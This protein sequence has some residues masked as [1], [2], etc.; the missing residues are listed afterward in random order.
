MVAEKSLPI[1]N[2]PGSGGPVHK[3]LLRAFNGYFQ[4]QK[5]LG[6]RQIPHADAV[7]DPFGAVIENA[8]LLTFPVPPG[9]QYVSVIGIIALADKLFKLVEIGPLLRAEEFPQDRFRA[10]EIVTFDTELS[11]G[12]ARLYH[13][14][15][16]HARRRANA[17][18]VSRLILPS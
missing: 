18:P 1:V 2:I 3:S 10:R 9:S 11:D 14:L 12:A 17:S 4:T 15:D 5:L 7:P 13:A 8:V 6:R 16:E